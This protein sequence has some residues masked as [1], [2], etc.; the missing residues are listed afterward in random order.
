MSKRR[1]RKD[2]V[3]AKHFGT[4]SWSP[5]AS[6]KPSVNSQSKNDF[7]ARE[8]VA[9][10]RDNAEQSAKELAVKATKKDL[11]KSVLI[12]LAII[13]LEVVLYLAWNK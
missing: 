4:I 2:K 6:N 8:K 12:A 13:T 7:R 5:E 9:S 1:T 11:V 3:E 10:R